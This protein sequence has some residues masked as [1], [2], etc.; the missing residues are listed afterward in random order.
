MTE[1]S[2][3]WG[4]KACERGLNLEAA[5]AEYRKLMQ[6]ER[7][8]FEYLLSTPVGP[9][10]FDT[11]AARGIINALY[12]KSSPTKADM[13]E[14]LNRTD[15]QAVLLRCPGVGRA[16]VDYIFM[17]ARQQRWIDA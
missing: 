14:L 12:P 16:T 4:Y 10:T 5:R 2:M 8:L 13:I 6:L 1:L 17:T 11:R 3:E 9:R 15:A 7:P